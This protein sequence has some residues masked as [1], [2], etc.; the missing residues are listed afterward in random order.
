MAID[1]QYVSPKFRIIAERIISIIT[2]LENDI[3]KGKIT[4]ENK[5]S[6][7]ETGFLGRIQEVSI[8]QAKKYLEE[9]KSINK[10]LS[11]NEL[12]NISKATGINY[13]ELTTN[14]TSQQLQTIPFPSKESD[15][16][17]EIREIIVKFKKWDIDI[18][19]SFRTLFRISKDVKDTNDIWIHEKTIDN[20]LRNNLKNSINQKLAL[21]SDS[22][23]ERRDFMNSCFAF[24]EDFLTLI[25]NRLLY[26]KPLEIFSQIKL[27]KMKDQELYYKE[28]SPIKP[29]QLSEEI[30]NFFL[31]KYNKN[32]EENDNPIIVGRIYNYKVYDDDKIT[33]L[34]ELIMSDAFRRVFESVDEGIKKLLKIG[35]KIH[36]G[37]PYLLEQIIKTYNVI[38]S[39]LTSN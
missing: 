36:S 11:N 8:P 5:K 29:P 9:L 18:Y 26:N 25:S 3:L 22:D 2:Q 16:S 15:Y 20:Y 32:D 27:E 19:E 34:A 21:F 37:I 7:L 33:N 30:M 35:K 1:V 14:V 23:T 38:C 13:K 39:N 10:M 6:Y 24:K 31:L 12:D 17:K 4:N 28:Y